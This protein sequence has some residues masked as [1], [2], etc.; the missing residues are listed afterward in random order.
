MKTFLLIALLL[1]A[2]SAAPTEGEKQPSEPGAPQELQQEDLAPQELQ[3]ED[4]APQ[5]L[6]QEDLAPQ[7]LQQED[8]AAP[9]QVLEKGGAAPDARISCPAHW[10]FHGFQ[11]FR[12]YPSA[13]TWY[14]AEE[15]CNSEGAHL[16]SVSDPR[17]ENFLQGMI[18][19]AG[20][21]TG[22]LGGFN[23]QG[24]WMWI[25]R[26][27]LYY[28]HWYS[29]HSTSSHPCMFLFSQH[30]WS[31]SGCTSSLGFLCSKSPFSC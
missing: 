16:A 10:E 20:R 9:A 11:C 24:R 3:Q 23:L 12:F 15:F 5:E 29:Q 14:A 8:E 22:W 17:Q 28:S 4:L 30:G 19:R 18:H 6:Q 2:A 31:N 21:T 27:G 7:E 1:S 25:D 13:K 26:A